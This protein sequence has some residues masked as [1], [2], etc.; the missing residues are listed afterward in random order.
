MGNNG[1]L[2]Q[3]SRH[4]K[5]QGIQK[6]CEDGWVAFGNR[7]I[8]RYWAKAR[9]NSTG[10]IDTCPST[11]C[12]L[13]DYTPVSQSSGVSWNYITQPEAKIV[14][15]TI[16]A[17]LITN[18]EW[19]AIARDVEQVKSNWSGGSIGSGSL[20]KPNA[21]LSNG[22]MIY[23]VAD[24]S[25]W[26]DDKIKRGDL[27]VN[28]NGQTGYFYYNKPQTCSITD[29]S[30]LI[31]NGKESFLPYSMIG[32]LGLYGVCEGTGNITLDGSQGSDTVYALRRGDP[33]NWTYGEGI[34]GFRYSELA[35]RSNSVFFRCVK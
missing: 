3:E 32:P 24:E 20:K 29:Y 10:N 25:E 2:I 5:T 17:H 26:V 9:N 27:Y 22:E 31:F 12:S 6:S 23:S 7:C 19:M 4:P 13:D 34:F 14:C 15:E 33:A 28:F 16:G 8:M 21:V 1:Y 35:H 18:A 30:V 11:G